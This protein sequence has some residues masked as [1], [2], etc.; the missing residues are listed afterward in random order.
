MEPNEEAFFAR[1]LAIQ[2]RPERG[3]FCQKRGKAWR[4]N[5]ECLF[6]ICEAGPAF[7]GPEMS[8]WWKMVLEEPHRV[9]FPLGMLAGI[10]GVMLWPLY[11]A[12][13]LGFN[14]I[15]AH[16]R[17]MVEG[18]LGAFVLGFLGTS[19]PRLA[20]N[21]QWFALEWL[22]LLG[23]WLAVVVNAATGRVPAA[24]GTFAVLLV[25][26]WLGLAGRWAVGRRDTP[27]PGFALAMAGVL[28]AAIAAACLAWDGG[29][30]LGLIGVT[31]A[32]LWLFQGFLLLPLMG[33]G[34]YM[35][36]R[37]FGHPSSHSFDDSPRPPAG[38]WPRVGSAV[39]WGL[40]IVAS[41]ALEVYGYPV[42]GQ[43]L[44]AVVIGVWF[45]IE[46][47]VFRP[48]KTPST[49]ATVVRLAIIGLVAGCAAAG[50]WPAARIGSLHLAFAAGFGLMTVT[51]AT[52][53]VFGHA[54]RHDLLAGR[55]IWLRWIA[56]LLILAA[57]TR[58]SAD[59][60]P[61]VQVSHHNY[62]AWTWALAGVI[63]L[64]IM[65]RYLFRNEDDPKP[66]SNCPRRR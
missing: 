29:R 55:V 25:G 8:R 34:P 47:P 48:A 18:M 51:V 20:G 32:K 61:K 24:D 45:A 54:G 65:A 9:F 33:I 39:F 66:R 14:P 63:W 35:L 6:L 3:Y 60:L 64:A 44:R 36:P 42:L 53:V 13:W 12:K 16:P 57:T 19:F 1:H 11:Y 10:G 30:W 37:F 28:G 5:T 15:D 62:A 38:W 7:L 31:W 22:A 52:R 40:H 23:L 50:L 49:C 17:L 2:L 59:F 4:I 56:G 27:P 58:M 21:R 46:T 41:F 43:V 26:L